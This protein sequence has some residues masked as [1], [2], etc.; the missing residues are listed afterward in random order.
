MAST[1][2]PTNGTFTGRQIRQTIGAAWGALT[3]RPLGARSGVVAGTPSTVVSI[4]GSTYSVLAH[5][6]VL[7]VESSLIAGP[8]NYSFDSTQ[9][10]TVNAADATFDRADLLSITM[11]DTSEGDASISG[12]TI[13]YT[14][15]TPAATP[16]QPATPAK[17]IP[18][19]RISVPKLGTGSATITL[20]AP[21]AVAAGGIVPCR[22]SAEYPS[23]P[24]VGQY[25]DDATLGLLRWNGTT[26][27]ALRPLAW[28]AISLASGYGTQNATPAYVLDA[29]GNV[30][31]AGGISKNSGAFTVGTTIATLPVGARP[32]R[33]IEL[34]V[35]CT[36]VGGFTTARLEITSAGAMS[37]FVAAG[38]TAVSWVSLDGLQFAPSLPS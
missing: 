19:A 23:T 36:D 6:G 35:A 28:A 37:V 7:D 15:G 25:V 14:P 22:T 12:P 33:N 18:F 29:S 1:L 26:W 31:L 17:S 11:S 21:F 8:Y 27:A 24:Y 5:K 13:T 32:T 10:G 9:T 38:Q 30:Q 4:S 34:S 20:I 16:T 2:W 3:G